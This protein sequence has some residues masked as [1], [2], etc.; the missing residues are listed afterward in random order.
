MGEMNLK[1]RLIFMDDILVFFQNFE[2]PLER[3]ESVFS[4][5]KQYGLKLKPS[6][7]EFFKTKLN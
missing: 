7:C 3:L 2:E 4:R 1:E 6:K 5:L